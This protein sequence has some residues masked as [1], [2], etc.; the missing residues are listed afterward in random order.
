MPA[1]ATYMP[2]AMLALVERSDVFDAK[3]HLVAWRAASER[4]GALC[5]GTFIL[6]EAGLFDGR[7]VTTN[8]GLAP[9][10]R[11]RYPAVSVDKSRMLVPLNI[12]A[13]A[14]AVTLGCG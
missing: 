2:D 14:G 6:A 3:T 8:W 11:Q 13:T 5:I 12:G 4:L 7:E 10:F 1:L 9:L